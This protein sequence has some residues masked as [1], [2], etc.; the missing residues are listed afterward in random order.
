MFWHCTSPFRLKARF[1]AMQVASL[2]ARQISGP[3]KSAPQPQPLSAMPPTP[4]SSTAVADHNSIKIPRWVIYCQAGLL[5]V[6]PLTCFFLGLAAAQLSRPAATATQPQ[7]LCELTG[8]LISNDDV[9]KTGVVIAL[10]LDLAPPER[11]DPR[12]LHPESFQE[13]GNPAIMAIQQ[14]GGAV[15]R[16]GEAGTFR[17]E[18]SSPGRYLLVTIAANPADMQAADPALG[19]H[20]LD[21][22]AISELS[23]WFLP[24]ENLYRGH[25][26]RIL[27]IQAQGKT[28]DLGALSF[29]R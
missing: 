4:E 1:L 28:L 15:A 10:P 21:R 22:A 27:P 23:R 9:P 14:R 13:L 25:P 3:G 29:P 26:I 19:D 11:L 7:Q 17:L 5:C 12:P 20:G 8:R 24:L 16:S 2:L 6:V 18:V